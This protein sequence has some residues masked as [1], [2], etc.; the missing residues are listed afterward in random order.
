ML[1]WAATAKRKKTLEARRY[2]QKR[3]IWFIRWRSNGL[4]IKDDVAQSGLKKFT[5]FRS[6]EIHACKLERN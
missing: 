3:C 4:K 2:V 5:E 1:A 6:L